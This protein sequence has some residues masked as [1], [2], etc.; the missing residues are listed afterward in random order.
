M[1]ARWFGFSWVLLSRNATT[2]LWR[3]SNSGHGSKAYKGAGSSN[4]KDFNEFRQT[5]PAKHIE[6]E[7]WWMAN[8]I[9][10]QER[11]ELHRAIWNIANDLRGSVFRVDFSNGKVSPWQYFF[12]VFREIPSCRAISRWES[13]LTACSSLISW[14][15]S[16]LIISLPPVWWSRVNSIITGDF[17]QSGSLLCQR[18]VR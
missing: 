8:N 6:W 4:W 3:R 18:F 14:Y 11:A 9:R 7:W 12:T 5:L 1:V 13:P 2:V 10:E 17:G 16:T 15:W